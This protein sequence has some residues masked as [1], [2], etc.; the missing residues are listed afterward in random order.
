MMRDVYLQSGLCAVTALAD[1]ASEWFRV[2]MSADMSFQMVTARERRRTVGTVEVLLAR[3]QFHV[4]IQA[5]TVLEA[6]A[7]DLAFEHEQH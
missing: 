3:M 4:A 5:A 7:A 6:L 2:V 1:R